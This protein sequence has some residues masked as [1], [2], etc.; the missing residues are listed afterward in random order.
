MV[1]PSLFIKASWMQ[2]TDLIE[3]RYSRD[4]VSYSGVSVHFLAAIAIPNSI[5]AT[6]SLMA[7]GLYADQISPCWQLTLRSVW[8]RRRCDLLLE[9]ISG[10]SKERRPKVQQR[11]KAQGNRTRVSDTTLSLCGVLPVGLMGG[12][13][14]ASFLIG[15][16]LSSHPRIATGFVTLTPTGRALISESAR[17]GAWRTTKEVLTEATNANVTD[18]RQNSRRNLKSRVSSVPSIYTSRGVK[19]SWHTV[20]DSCC[21]RW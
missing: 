10:L 3:A 12:I 7:Q 16:M 5:I 14:A 11:S 6:L 20:G 9:N 17:H 2:S 1:V 8:I 21:P 4:I 15:L 13:V 19:W 18:S